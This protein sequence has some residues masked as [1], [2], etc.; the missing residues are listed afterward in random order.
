M[1]GSSFSQN[2]KITVGVAVLLVSA[3]ISWGIIYQ[4][5]N[6]LE[7]R[8]VRVENKLDKIIESRVTLK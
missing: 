4:K 3:A 7:D 1:G 5:V 6:N 2:S 8:M